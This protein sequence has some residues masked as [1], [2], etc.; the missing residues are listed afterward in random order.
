MSVQK[1]NLLVIVESFSTGVYAVVRDIVCNLDQNT[2]EILLLHSLRD[3]SPAD[4]QKDFEQ[5]NIR[6]QYLPMG[7]AAS[8]L[9]AVKAIK[10]AIKEFNPDCIH[11]HSSKAGFLGRLAAHKTTGRL[12]YTPHGISFIRTDVGS[13]KK[14]VFYFLERFIQWYTPSRM[15]AV[16]EAELANV[17]RL[18]NN[19]T[20]IANFIP[21]AA[22]KQHTSFDS[23]VVGITGRITPAKNPPLFNRIAA[24]LPSV[25]FLWVGDGENRSEITE[26]NITISG[27]I[28]RNDALQRL[29]EFA[30]Y[31]QTSNWE[32]MPIALLEAM[33]A[34][35][36]VIATRIPAHLNLIEDGIN[37]IICDVDNEKQFADAITALLADPKRQKML[38]SNARKT[39]LEKHNIEQAIA[40]YTAE[41]LGLND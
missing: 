21:V 6:L 35:L 22:I 40:N 26:P 37:G 25:S 2:F 29:A 4:Y 23:A 17:K 19:S 1:C 38:G 16:S 10:Q 20:V 7:S 9:P 32:G 13:L 41:Y 11:V 8:Y 36:P 3:D 28:S 12:F 27:Q 14:S 5:S 18:T 39:V 33:G 34:G 31:I 15:I 30:I 24:L